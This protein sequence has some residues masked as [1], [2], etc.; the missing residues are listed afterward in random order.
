VVEAD[1]IGGGVLTP[2]AVAVWQG[3]ADL[4]VDD[5]RTGVTYTDLVILHNI[6]E[7]EPTV[8]QSVAVQ[9]LLA[10]QRRRIR[11]VGGRRRPEFA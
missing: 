10:T 2:A 11:R 3:R 4:W 5:I 9:S 1:T 8:V 6:E 7:Q